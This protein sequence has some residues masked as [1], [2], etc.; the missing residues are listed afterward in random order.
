M[1]SEWQIRESTQGSHLELLDGGGDDGGGNGAV[2]IVVF[3]DCYCFGGGGGSG[4]VD[5]VGV[6]LWL[7]M[8]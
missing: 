6:I 4:V 8:L 2:V 3:G 7:L 1:A 5:V